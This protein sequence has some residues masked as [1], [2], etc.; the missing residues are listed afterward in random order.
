ML[1]FLNC[2]FHS[3]Y[4]CDVALLTLPSEWTI[5]MVCRFGWF[6]SSSVVSEHW[7]ASHS[8]VDHWRALRLSDVSSVF[9]LSNERDM[10]KYLT[11]P[12]LSSSLTYCDELSTDCHNGFYQSQHCHQHTNNCAV[13]LSSYPGNY[14]YWHLS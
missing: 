5:T 9:D 8:V 7:N 2:A 6:M 11:R 14:I 12:D 3:L 1:T 13:L 4:C 10:L